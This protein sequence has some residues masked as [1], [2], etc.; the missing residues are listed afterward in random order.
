[1]P[2]DL[3]KRH[4]RT[5]GSSH[6]RSVSAKARAGLCSN[7]SINV[8][9]WGIIFRAR[10]RFKLL[11][12]REPLS[13]CLAKGSGQVP[14]PSRPPKLLESGGLHLCFDLAGLAVQ[15]CRPT[16]SNGLYKTEVIHRRAP[17]KTKTAVELGTLK[18]V[19]CFNYQRLLESIDDV[20]PAETEGLY[21][22]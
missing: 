7:C 4:I 9:N 2:L 19:V 1:M 20:P 8:R 12:A 15:D 5:I 13:C 17:W 21:Y 14:L 6:D 11:S 3:V 10:F 16:E 18:W 22:Q